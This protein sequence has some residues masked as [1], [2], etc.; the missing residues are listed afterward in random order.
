MADE[1]VDIPRAKRGGRPLCHVVDVDG[2][3]VLVRTRGPLTP[4]DREALEDLIRAVRRRL[5][6]EA[7]GA[8]DG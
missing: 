3:R 4:R 7:E 8:A 6:A 1:L 2:E 5:Q